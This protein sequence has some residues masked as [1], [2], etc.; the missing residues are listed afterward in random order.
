[1]DA[2]N[3]EKHIEDSREQN[4]YAIFIQSTQKSIKNL[5]N[6]CLKC[7]GVHFASKISKTNRKMLRD[8]QQ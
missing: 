5:Y 6:C 2:D 7:L 8:F 3:E 1:M 4:I